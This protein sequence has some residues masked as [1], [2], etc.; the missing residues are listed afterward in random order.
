MKRIYAIPEMSNRDHLSPRVSCISMDRLGYWYND[1]SFQSSLQV[2]VYA[3][4]DSCRSTQ[5]VDIILRHSPHLMTLQADRS[6]NETHIC[7]SQDDVD[8]LS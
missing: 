8:F 6:D 3:Q 1:Q 2:N 7:M 5:E 4:D